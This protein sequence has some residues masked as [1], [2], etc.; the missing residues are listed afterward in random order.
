MYRGLGDEF[1]I[2]VPHVRKASRAAQRRG[3]RGSSAEVATGC[4]IEPTHRIGFGNELP[5]RNINGKI[6]NV[7]EKAPLSWL[8]LLIDKG[9]I[10]PEYFHLQL[11][12]Y[13]ALTA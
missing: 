7:I 4:K 11:S 3:R 6:E 10:N 1:G 5:A 2:R 8:A 13:M 12:G 9:P